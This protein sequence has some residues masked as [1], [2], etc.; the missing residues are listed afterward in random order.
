MICELHHFCALKIKNWI[1][2][3]IKFLFI[4]APC[5]EHTAF[6]P[7]AAGPSKRWP[8][9]LAAWNN[10]QWKSIQ[11]PKY[12]H[13]IRKT[14]LKRIN[15][16]IIV[17]LSYNEGGSA[18]PETVQSAKCRINLIRSSSLRPAREKYWEKCL[19]MFKN[20]YELGKKMRAESKNLYQIRIKNHV[21][22][23][24]IKYAR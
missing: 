16:I 20:I 10:L 19:R 12:F 24:W 7:L 3:A 8:K 21:P 22:V 1:I 9:N 4:I 5:T 15:S 2:F 14:M 6:S 13:S 18:S 11:K 23:K 17:K